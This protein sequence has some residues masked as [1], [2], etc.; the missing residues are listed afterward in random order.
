MEEVSEVKNNKK[1]NVTI[2]VILVLIFLGACSYGFVSYLKNNSGSG[3][4]A[5]YEKMAPTIFAISEYD[6][7][8]E[9]YKRNIYKLFYDND[10]FDGSYFLTKIPSRAKN[11][12][13]Y[14]NFSNKKGTDGTD[15]DIAIILEKNDFKS[16]S[17]YIISASNDLLFY[18][19]FED[20]LPTITSFNKG[21]KIFMDKD[22]LE[23]SPS[24]GIMIHF[25]DSKKA[26]LYVPEKKVFE[27]FY[28]YTQDDI[29]SRS[30]DMESEGDYEQESDSVADDFTVH[31]N[32]AKDTVTAQ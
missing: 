11:V 20:E 32:V 7:I 30:N 31:S 12:I 9:H 1:R 24:D 28:Q 27:E 16:S 17:I 25:K 21:A 22:V 2:I 14:G 10:Y 5:N 19:E 3:A 26:L 4:Y 23:K 6:K 18:K 15:K 29:D 13:A 8:E